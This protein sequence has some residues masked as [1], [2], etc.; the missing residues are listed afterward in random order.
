MPARKAPRR[1]SAPPPSSLGKFSE[2][3]LGEL[4]DDALARI[5][6]LRA[7]I[8]E[9]GEVVAHEVRGVIPNPKLTVLQAEREWVRKAWSTKFMG[10]KADGKDRN[11][12]E[13]G[14]DG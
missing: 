11:Y 9:E 7:E 12:F 5:A 2:E 1:K 13:R 6:S 14:P 8:G 10:G 3:T 4:V